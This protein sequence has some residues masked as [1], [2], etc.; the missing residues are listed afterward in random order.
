MGKPEAGRERRSES[1][2]PRPRRRRLERVV[3][4]P[5]AQTSDRLRLLV[6]PTWQDLLSFALSLAGV[7]SFLII[8]VLLGRLALSDAINI[9]PI[10]VPKT[11]A[12]EGYTSEVA[13]RR[14]QDEMRRLFFSIT[15]VPSQPTPSYVRQLPAIRSSRERD[16]DVFVTSERRPDIALNLIFRRLPF[17]ALVF[18]SIH[19]RLRSRTSS[20]GTNV[21]PFRE[22]SQ[23]SAKSFGL[24]SAPIMV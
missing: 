5:P 7:L 17:P 8:A 19:S 13:A 10:G 21:S 12:E 6:N 22:N 4:A 18:H 11:L 23:S 3:A 16:V 14:L 1:S 20:A 15:Q 9:E 2:S 24:C